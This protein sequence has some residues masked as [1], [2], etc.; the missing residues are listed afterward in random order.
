MYVYMYMYW[1]AT[2][3]ILLPLKY[4]VAFDVHSL[5]G[6]LVAL[7]TGGGQ[8]GLGRVTSLSIVTNFAINNTLGAIYSC[9]CGYC[10]ENTYVYM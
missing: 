6:L 1:L 2:L 9:L 7:I 10:L 5:V 3:A 4:C 8:S